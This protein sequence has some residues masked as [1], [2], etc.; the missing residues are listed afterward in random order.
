MDFMQLNSFV[1]VVEYGSF[2]CAAQKLHMAHSTVTGH[3]Q[4]LE[5]ELNCTLIKRSTRTMTL[6]EKG[7]V[8][9]QF[10]KQVLGG[11]AEMIS[12]LRRLDILRRINI[13]T[14]SCIG[15]G[16]IP[17]IL[18]KYR[19]KKENVMFNLMQGQDKEI[20]A[21]LSSGL[22]SIGFLRGPCQ[23]KDTECVL[24]GQSGYRLLVPQ[25][26]IF[27]NISAEAA[28][29]ADLAESYPLVL[30]AR[31]EDSRIRIETR[32]LTRFGTDREF[33]SPAVETF[34]MENII[35]YVRSGLG[36]SL[37]PCFVAKRLKQDPGIRI[38]DAQDE[39]I[40]P[41]TVYMIYR[42]AETNQAVL[43]FIQF[44]QNWVRINQ[45]RTEIAFYE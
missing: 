8:V 37:V 29:P 22:I 12:E 27:D 41:V 19:R 26:G 42:K 24:L 45:S 36:F 39:T 16:L 6:T 4:R 13:A 20:Q 2:C 31:G 5:R 21:M 34:G 9:Y 38:L 25:G 15:Y 30:A 44:I 40:S 7:Q 28:D 23:C 18:S 33:P 1:T 35:N 11:Q 43:D 17:E 32:W 10:A 14:T 3:I